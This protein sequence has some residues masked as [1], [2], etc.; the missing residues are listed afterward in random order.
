MN[1]IGHHA[2]RTRLD[3]ILTTGA[4]AH[5]YIF[6]GP[7]HVGKTTVAHAFASALVMG[8]TTCTERITHPDIQIISPEHVTTK[9]GR[10]RTKDIGVETARAIAVDAMTTPLSGVRRVIIV[11]EAEYL[12]VAAQNALLKTLEEPAAQT[13][14]IMTAVHEGRL[15]PTVRSRMQRVSLPR[16]AEA[17]MA[18]AAAEMF[19]DATVRADVLVAAHGCPGIM[20]RCAADDDVR[21]W[22][23]AMVRDAHVLPDMSRAQKIAYAGESARD[24]ARLQ[25]ALIVWMHVWRAQLYAGDTSRAQMLAAAHAALTALEQTNAQPRLVLEHMLLTLTE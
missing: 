24:V 10:V 6:V 9:H 1:I 17:Q 4:V 22:Y 12:T 7:A 13:V 11:T 14:L 15:L 21:A 2:V 16:V 18:T 3:H 5:A 8:R 20:V 23:S 19:D 25:Q